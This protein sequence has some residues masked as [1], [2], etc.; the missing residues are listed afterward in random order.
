VIHRSDEFLKS[1]LLNYF[2]RYKT[3]EYRSFASQRIELSKGQTVLEKC[4]IIMLEFVYEEIEKKR[5]QAI[6]NMAE[7]VETSS[8]G[9][10]FRNRLIFY[11]EESKFTP[12][13]MEIAK[14]IE[15]ME[16]VKVA[17]EVKDRQD[18]M[19]LRGACMRALE[20]YPDHPGILILSAFSE[21]NEFQQSSEMAI[22]EF[23]RA[24][25]ALVKFPE[26]EDNIKA[27]SGFLE[28][29]KQKRLPII[30]SVCYVI[31]EEFPQRDMA[32]SVLKY[33]D[34]TSEGGMLAYKILLET[35]LE[36]IK[37]VN[38]HILES[39]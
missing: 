35:S 24:V 18:A 4:I 22:G 5:R 20:S 3:P 17:T 34:I 21:I 37:L 14:K 7:A 23:R 9:E 15:P 1:A 10:S 36:K 6:L 16:W 11:L 27:M 38:A 2:E 30:N 12:L 19:Q 33:A 8:D 28:I 29:I 25:K 32:R 26:R 13:L 31:L 39:E